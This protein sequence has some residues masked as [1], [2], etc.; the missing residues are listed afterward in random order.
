MAAAT[1]LARCRT[2]GPRSSTRGSLS[3]LPLGFSEPPATDEDLRRMARNLVRVATHLRALQEH[4]GESLVLA[5][6]PEPNCLLESV[7]Q[8]IAFLEDRVFADAQSY[9]PEDCLREH[10]GI[11][12]DL[13][14]LAVVGEDPLAAFGACKRSEIAVGKIQV[15]AALEAR[16]AMDAGALDRLLACAEPRYLHQCGG[17]SADARTPVLRALDLD[18][19]AARRS[20]WQRC[21][22]IVTHFHVPVFWDDP[23]AFGSTRNQVEA[24]V[25]GLAGDAA[26]LLE[27]ETYTWEVLPEPEFPRAADLEHAQQNLIAG[28]ARELAYVDSLRGL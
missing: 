24:A 21:D 2:E 15:S 16:L 10:L 6:E 5:I 19:L 3:T 20:N 13:C 17:F 28:I 22:R 23:G 26:P 4:T 14:H 25:H 9:M 27:V 8:T 1:F 18:R 12:I 11:C 7:A